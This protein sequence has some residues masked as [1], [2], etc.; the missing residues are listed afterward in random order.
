MVRKIAQSVLMFLML[1]CLMGATIN[2]DAGQPKAVAGMPGASSTI[3]GKG[4][5]AAG[6]NEMLSGFQFSASNTKKV[7][8]SGTTKTWGGNVWSSSVSVGSGNF[9]V[10]AAIDALNMTTMQSVTV[11]ASANLNVP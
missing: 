9:D 11:S 4:T 1:S 7:E 10:T 3:Q 5:Y 8:V 6:P 2:F